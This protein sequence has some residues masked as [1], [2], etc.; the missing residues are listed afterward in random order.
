MGKSFRAAIVLVSLLLAAPAFGQSNY[1]TVSG[2]VEDSTRAVLPGVSV[3]ATN[4]ATGVVTS[5]FSNESGVYNFASLTPGVYRVSAELPGFRTSTY[6]DVQLGNAERVRL[7]FTLSVASLATGVEVTV[8]ADT[9][10]ATSSS[11]IGE[12]LSQQR[13]QDLPTISNSVLEL[14]RTMPGIRVNADGVS[15]SF[16]GLTSFGTINMQRDG[17]EAGG[18]A[19]W[20]SNANSA[21]YMSPDLIGEVRLIVAPVD[22]ELGRGNAQIQ[23][24]TRSGTNQ[25]RGTA[26]WAARNSALDANTWNNNNDLDPRTGAW[27]PTRPDWHNTHEFTGSYS[28]PIVKNKTFF[29][30]LWDSNVVNL[31]T[32]PNSLVLTPCARNGIFRYFDN[33]NNGNAIQPTLGGTAP[34]PVIAVVD[35]LGKPLPPATNPD[36]TPHNGILRYASVFGPLLNTPSRE[37]CSDAVV[38]RASTATGTWDLN[39]TRVDPTGF[40]AK[41]LAKMPLP[42]NYEVD[43][44]D[45]LNTAGYRW[46]RNERGGTEGIFATNT[47]GLTSPT[48]LAR[49]QINGKIDHNFNTSHKLGVTYTIE[50]SS[51]NAQGRLESW[52]DGFRSSVFRRPQILSSSFTSTLSPAIVNEAR[53]GMRRTGGNT[54]NAFNNPGTGEAAQAFFPNIAGYPVFIGLGTGQVNFQSNQPYG[55]GSTATYFDTSSLWSYADSLSWTKGKHTFKFGGEIRRSRSLGYDAGINVTSTPRAVG[56]DA[57]LAAIP[58]GAIGSANMPGLAGTAVTGNNVRMRNLLSFLAGSLGSVSQ[59]YYMQDPRKLDA[60]EDFKTFTHRV[61]DVHQNEAGFFFKDDW[62]ALKSLT[63]NIGVRWDYYGSLY[64]GFGLT[65]L[66]TQGGPAIFGISGRSF[67]GWMKPGARA[68]PTVFEYVGKNSPN[69]EKTYYP[70]DFN[71]FGPAFGF[72]WQVPWFGVGKTTVRGGYQL[73]Y[74]AGQVFNAVNQENLVPGS[75]LQAT[76]T[77]DSGANA[78]LDLTKLSSLVPVPQIFK[79]MQP[80]PLTDRVQNVFI[81]QPGL[82]NPYVQNLTLSVTRSVGSNLTVDLR[83]VGT[84]ARKQWNV[85][86]NINYPNFLYNGLKEAFDAARA[87]DDSNPSLQVLEDMFRGINIAGAGFGPVGSVFNGVQQTAGMHLRQSTGTAAGI[88]GNLRSNLANGNYAAAAGILNKLNY[89]S[90]SNPTLP[91]IPAGVNGAVMRFNGFPENFIVTNPQFNQAYMIAS[92]N[93][94]NYH[95]MEAQVTLRPVQG[96]NMQSTYTWSKNLGIRAAA[97]YTNPVDRHADYALLDDTRVHDFRTNGTFTLPI[98]PNRWVL[99]RSTGTLAR[100]LENWQMS[101]IVNLNSGQPMNL[102][103]QSMLYNNGTPD[104]VGGI[105]PKAAKVEWPNGAANGSYFGV[106]AVRQVRDPQCDGVTTL[107]NLRTNCTLTAV[108]DAKTGQVLLKNSLPGTRGLLGQRVVEGPGQWRFDANLSKTIRISET[109]NVQFRLDALDVFNHAEPATPILDINNANFGL[110]T[111]PN[112]KSTLHRQFQAQVRFNF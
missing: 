86:F 22:A 19:R 21:T 98:G 7:N 79:P 8:A 16:A 66:P 54:F 1:A 110:I 67:D 20:G 9:L 33:W 35:G 32:T 56:G 55:G 74:N 40:V 53:A 93:S 17:V 97:T 95:S 24:M 50:R 107:Q 44:G 30:A 45:G 4:N 61:R 108:S 27:K 75:T 63:L 81:P 104:I 14:Y 76:Y 11:S 94:N 37:D 18:G 84:L 43:G 2:T 112:A 60:F 73:T 10:L 28:G 69:P 48:N 49:K 96:I 42:N 109:R 23:F 39:R 77:G 52:P 26:L 111:G 82:V 88:G 38:G 3:T 36:G 68:E 92:V 13:V 47:G 15:G 12:V 57:P 100:I 64:D 72:A 80:V 87:G 71:N 51:G 103:S 62:K 5:V 58:T 46:V 90:A 105:D 31:R 29:F 70:N 41:V 65:P 91:V 25:F 34:T 59:F 78:Y 106:D 99:G 102:A 6:T 101:W 85:F 83:Y 89:A